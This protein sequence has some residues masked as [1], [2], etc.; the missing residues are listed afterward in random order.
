MQ[1]ATQ[2]LTNNSQL[3]K[4]RRDIARVRTILR[5]K[6]GANERRANTKTT[7]TLTG[8]VVSDKMNKTVTVLIER[9]VTHPMY[10]KIMTRSKKYHAHDENER[11]PR[12]RPGA[13]RGMPPDFA[14]QGLA[15]G[16]AGGKGAHGVSMCLARRL[17][18][19]SRIQPLRLGLMIRTEADRPGRD[20]KLPAP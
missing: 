19:A 11:V 1:K 2:Q 7:R 17:G 18:F 12:G 5:E 10:G 16:Q 4:M 15:G 8:R 14:D 3:K 6:A 9:R 13:D 20:P